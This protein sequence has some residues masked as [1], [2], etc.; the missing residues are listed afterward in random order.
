[1]LLL[2]G[3]KTSETNIRCCVCGHWIHQLYYGGF[4]EGKYVDFNTKSFGNIN[5]TLCCECMS[6]IM[7]F[8]SDEELE[9]D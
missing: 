7:E 3:E 5:V 6:K 2:V 4:I 9:Y 8:C 1:M